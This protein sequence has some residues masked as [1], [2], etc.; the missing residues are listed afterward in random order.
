MCLGCELYFQ[1][2]YD[3]QYATDEPDNFSLLAATLYSIYSIC[4]GR[5]NCFFLTGWDQCPVQ[6]ENTQQ[7]RHQRTS[8]TNI[9]IIIIIYYKIQLC[10]FVFRP[11]S[12]FHR[13]PYL[14]LIT[15]Y[16][17][18]FNSSLQ[19]TTRTKREAT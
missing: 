3:P 8:A 7:T 17:C 2:N 1:N 15:F 11:P 6:A 10:L 18:H 16:F 5:N 9:V 4:I 13:K 19:G 14:E 12:I